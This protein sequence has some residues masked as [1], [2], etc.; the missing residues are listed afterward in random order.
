MGR[1]INSHMEGLMGNKSAGRRLSA[2]AQVST[3]AL[4]LGALAAAAAV[5]TG[6]A[7]AASPHARAAR[8][9]DLN[10][11][12]NL[13]LSNKKGFELKE[14]GSAKGSLGGTIYI[15]L[16]VESERA[17][18]AKI[19][20]YPSGGSLSATATGS[21]RVESS[22]T[23]SFSGKLNITGG[24]G[25]Y[26]KAKGSGLSFS[27]TVHRPGDSVSVRVSGNMSY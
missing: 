14:A 27:G 4:A 2:R 19:Q 21:Y 11:S 25:R 15:Q 22:S 10:D 6:A 26:S 17:V 1:D 3:A 13:S 23:A 5:G 9:L 12:A 18:A 8:T 20:V 7:G 16:K 24:S